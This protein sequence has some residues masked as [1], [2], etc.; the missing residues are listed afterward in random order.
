MVQIQ[1]MH[2]TKIHDRHKKSMYFDQ[3]LYNVEMCAF[4]Q[5]CHMLC[6][7]YLNF[8]YLDFL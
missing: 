7:L 5:V 1:Q 6:F 8:N 4:Y 2:N 3:I